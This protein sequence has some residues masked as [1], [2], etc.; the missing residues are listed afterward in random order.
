MYR[1][2]Q[3]QLITSSVE[4]TQWCRDHAYILQELIVFRCGFYQIISFPRQNNGLSY[5]GNVGEDNRSFK[6][7]NKFY[8][9]GYL[10]VPLPLCT[11]CSRW[12]LNVYWPPLQISMSSYIRLVR[13]WVVDGAWTVDAWLIDHCLPGGSAWYFFLLQHL[14]LLTLLSCFKYDMNGRREAPIRF[15]GIYLP[16][17]C[18]PKE[19]HRSPLLLTYHAGHFSALV[20]MKNASE[21]KGGDRGKLIMLCSSFYDVW[22]D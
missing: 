6:L 14:D 20:A 18:N 21:L 12:K 4:C 3:Y 15:G 9:L 16:V 2:F 5:V 17:E 8:S 13:G 19:C 7:Q 11:M 22:K 1:V 10:W